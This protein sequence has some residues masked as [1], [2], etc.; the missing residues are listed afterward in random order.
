MRKLLYSFVALCVALMATSCLY[1]K[2]FG[3]ETSGG[4]VETGFKAEASASVISA[5]GEDTVTFRAIYNGEDV[6][7]E[8]TLFDAGTNEP[9]EGMS[10]S[11][12]AAGVYT[13]YVTYGEHK[14]KDIT[15]TAVMG[16]DLSDKNETGLSVTFST[17]LIQVGKNYAAFIVRYNG[18]VLTAD[19]ITKVLVYDAA[20]DIALALPK[21]G[22]DT[23]SSEFS[24]VVVDGENNT[25][26]TLLAYSPNEAGSKSFWFGYKI[27]NTRETPLTI[28]AV[29]T[30]IPSS[31]VDA[32]PS[33]LNFKRRVMITQLTGIN[34]GYCPWLVCALHKIATESEYSQYADKYV[35]TAVHGAPYDN[36]YKVT[37]NIDGTDCDLGNLIHPAGSYPYI[38]YDLATSHSGGYGVMGDIAY[39]TS[40]LDSHFKSPARAAIA[41]R[42]E[43]KDNM[44]LVRASVK[45][46]HTAEYYVG[47]WLLESNLY[48]RQSNYTEVKEDYIDYHENVVRI[49]DSYNAKAKN[50]TGHSLGSITKGEKADHLF[51][52]ELDPNWKVENCHLVIFVSAVHEK[53]LQVINVVKTASLTSGVD[54]EYSK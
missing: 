7:A 14:S 31:P 34:C 50:F 3:E 8:S 13:F 35:H 24:Y 16:I 26:Y 37:V 15:I 9:L 5:N 43:F 39:I 4:A 28:T 40:A 54:F 17:N 30:N 42:T 45:V 33:N 41:A 52:M 23:I 36:V 32:D 51:V 38:Y 53:S 1:G 29:T 6:T 18:K 48:S 44:L 11:T 27:K 22:D 2:G 25:K 19:E 21:E 12:I 47:A 46:S 20:T 49:A 10:F